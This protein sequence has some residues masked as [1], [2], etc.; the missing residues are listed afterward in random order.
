MLTPESTQHPSIADNTGKTCQRRGSMA[1]GIFPGAKA[2]L[3]SRAPVQERHYQFKCILYEL[4]DMWSANIPIVPRL[5]VYR[6]KLAR[7]RNQ[8]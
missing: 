8:K 7:K 5:R 2:V 4:L 1:A 6:E 3:K